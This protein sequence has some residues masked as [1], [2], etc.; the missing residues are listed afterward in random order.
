MQ[1]MIKHLMLNCLQKERSYTLIIDNIAVFLLYEVKECEH[2]ARN[3][4][5]A[6]KMLALQY[7]SLLV[8]SLDLKIAISPAYLR[9]LL[10]KC[11]YS[12]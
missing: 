12:A 9:H 8:T 4:I 2:L 10:S 5:L 7:F 11:F 6:S 3:R 1:L